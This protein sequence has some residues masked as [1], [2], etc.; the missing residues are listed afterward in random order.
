VNRLDAELLLDRGAGLLDLGAAPKPL[1]VTLAPSLA[2]AL[3][4]PS[5]IPEVEPVTTAFFPL[6]I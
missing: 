4:M 2:S 6:S 3:A 5:P 1:I